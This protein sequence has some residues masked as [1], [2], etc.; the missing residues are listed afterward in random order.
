[1]LSVH[2]KPNRSNQTADSQNHHQCERWGQ[3]TAY[4]AA[5][6]LGSI[7]VDI[8]G[9]QD[10]QGGGISGNIFDIGSIRG[11]TGKAISIEGGNVKDNSFH[12]KEIEMGRPKTPDEKLK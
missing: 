4:S 3:N 5:A 12:V 11:V 6:A 9:S 8:K 10:P 2:S 1:M 7:G